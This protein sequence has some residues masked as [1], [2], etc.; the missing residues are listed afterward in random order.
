MAGRSLEFTTDDVVIAEDG[1]VTINNSEFAKML[2]SHIKK[3]APGN[4]GIFDNCDCKGK[5]I[6]EI[7]LGKVIPATTFRLDPGTVGIF[8]NCDCKG[9]I[10]QG[11][12]IRR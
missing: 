8:D 5:A 7:A 11:E 10:M 2:V 3:I 12:E 9:R 4:V 6:S 1:R